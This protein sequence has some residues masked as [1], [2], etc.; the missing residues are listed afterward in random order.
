MLCNLLI[1]PPLPYETPRH[2]LGEIVNQIH[3]EAQ[4][5]YRFEAHAFNHSFPV[6]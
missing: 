1:E 4:F 6:L 2:R 5:E 3:N